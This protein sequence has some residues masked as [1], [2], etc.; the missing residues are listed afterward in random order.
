[1]ARPILPQ[2]NRAGSKK[3]AYLII[4]ADLVLKY[5]TST[6][7]YVSTRYFSKLTLRAELGIKTLP[8][9]TFLSLNE[10]I[11]EAINFLNNLLLLAPLR[12]PECNS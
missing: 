3:S 1:M 8:I 10:D 7:L 6:N 11:V 4:E 5:I 2:Q 9:F 12:K